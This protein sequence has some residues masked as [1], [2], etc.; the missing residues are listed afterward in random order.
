[1]PVDF[2]MQLVNVLVMGALAGIAQ[3][4]YPEAVVSEVLTINLRSL[5]DLVVGDILSAA[6]SEP[7]STLN[8]LNSNTSG[9]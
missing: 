1:M 8:L 7:Q 9:G 3:A 6:V 4:F 5:Q 2:K